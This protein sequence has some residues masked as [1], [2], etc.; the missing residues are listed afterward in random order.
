MGGDCF[1]NGERDGEREAL[2]EGGPAIC[3]W[4][5]TSWLLRFCS[6]QASSQGSGRCSPG[7]PRKQPSPRGGTSTCRGPCTLSQRLA[8]CSWRV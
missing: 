2:G 7:Y 8:A 6:L 3:G 1:R 4:G 5:N